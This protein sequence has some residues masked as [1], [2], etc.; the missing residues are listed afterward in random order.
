MWTYKEER[1]YMMQVRFTLLYYWLY[2]TL[3][4]TLLYSSIDS[5]LVLTLVLTLVFFILLYRSIDFIQLN[6]T[7]FHLK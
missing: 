7:L 4:L 3:V 6:S 2:S 5:T 1:L